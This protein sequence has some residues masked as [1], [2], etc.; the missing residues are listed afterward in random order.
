MLTR[1]NFHCVFDN[2]PVHRDGPL[3]VLPSSISN[4][5]RSQLALPTFPADHGNLVRTTLP[6]QNSKAP[7]TRNTSRTFSPRN[8]PSQDSVLRFRVV[9][10][11]KLQDLWVQ[12]RECIGRVS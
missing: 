2:C 1:N 11:E 10:R 5:Y 3:C 4:D 6:R 7:Y 12:G 9:Q 8:S